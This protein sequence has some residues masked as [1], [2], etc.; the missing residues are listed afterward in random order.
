MAAT[1]GNWRNRQ[2]SSSHSPATVSESSF[3]L[4]VVLVIFDGNDDRSRIGPEA[5]KAGGRLA[6]KLE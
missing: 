4:L 1:I 2:E 5:N 3:L 6:V